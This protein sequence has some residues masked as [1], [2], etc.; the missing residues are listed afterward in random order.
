LRWRGAGKARAFK[1]SQK[2]RLPSFDHP[3]LVSLRLRALFGVDARAETLRQFLSAPAS[4]RAAASSLVDDVGFKKRNVADSLA[5][6][7]RGGALEMTKSQNKLVYRLR[8]Q[9]A[10]R[11]VLGDTPSVWPRWTAI[12][13][14]LA[15]ASDAL[16]R[17][18]KLPPRS[19]RVELHKLTMELTPLAERADFRTDLRLRDEDPD[20][21]EA[22][23][24]QLSTALARDASE[25]THEV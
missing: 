15:R 1:S 7:H 6:L 14:F 20:G 9:S 16:D 3:A 17:V 5:A 23:L 25:L 8:R 11:A 10:W 4:M 18:R 24:H 22:W 12:M 19:A 13:P 21:V 2:S